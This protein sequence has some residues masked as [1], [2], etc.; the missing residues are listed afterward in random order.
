M[1][2]RPAVLGLVVPSTGYMIE[3]GA[4]AFVARKQRERNVK[5]FSLYIPFKG[6]PEVTYLSFIGFTSKI[7]LPP[8]SMVS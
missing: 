8:N 7:I 5:G 4:H 3:R 1:V 6:K 2:S